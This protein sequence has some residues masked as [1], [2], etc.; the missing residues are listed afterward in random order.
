ME[1]SHSTRGGITVSVSSTEE[2]IADYC[3]AILN[4]N[5]NGFLSDYVKGLDFLPD[6]AITETRDRN[7]L[8][9]ALYNL[10]AAGYGI[11]CEIILTAKVQRDDDGV[12]LHKRHGD[13]PDQQLLNVLMEQGRPKDRAEIIRLGEAIQNWQQA[14]LEQVR[15]IKTLRN[16]LEV[17]TLANLQ[18]QGAR[19]EFALPALWALARGYEE[20][21]D[22]L[23]EAKKAT[24]TLAAKPF[25]VVQ[26][27]ASYRTWSVRQ[28]PEV[29]TLQP[30]GYWKLEGTQYRTTLRAQIADLYNITHL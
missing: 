23:A 4:A 12:S 21:L 10:S 24:E 15:E 29:W 7:D 25:P 14:D 16:A 8:H 30:N 9:C 19:H 3:E 20:E 11:L 13:C 26:I 27:K 6:G 1:L 18:L 28:V 22:G 17:E 2:D 5:T